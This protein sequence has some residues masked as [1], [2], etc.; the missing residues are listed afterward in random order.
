MSNQELK[1]Y[2]VAV[3]IRN[4]ANYGTDA[5]SIVLQHICYLLAVHNFEPEEL[6]TGVLGHMCE[7]SVEVDPKYK[8][9]GYNPDR[10]LLLDFENYYYEL[11]QTAE[12][13]LSELLS[14]Y[15]ILKQELRMQVVQDACVLAA[16]DTDAVLLVTL[17]PKV[18]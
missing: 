1:P 5:F 11:L 17:A 10:A 8:Y 4:T 7:Q 16:N 15:P 2:K 12:S 6:D 9:M 18:V 14:D 3:N 13:L